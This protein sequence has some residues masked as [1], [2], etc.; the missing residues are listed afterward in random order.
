MIA[1]LILVLLGL[2]IGDDFS[3][4]QNATLRGSSFAP[5]GDS[6]VCEDC[7]EV[8]FLDVGQGDAIYIR[9][10]DEFDILIDGGPNK[11]VLSQLGQVMPFWDHDIDIM[12]LTHPHSDHVT[13]LVEVLRRYNVKE[14]YYTGVPHTT[15][16]YIAWLEEISDQQIPMQIVEQPIDFKLG[17]DIVFQFLYPQKSLK[18]QEITE[19]NNSS[20]VNRLVYGETE[21]LLMG[22]A[23]KEVEEELIANYCHPELDS[24]DS[25]DCSQL[26]SDILK[27]GHHGSS[28]SSSEEFLEVVDPDLAVIQVG[29][30]NSFGHPHNIILDRLRRQEIEV[31]RNDLD[32]RISIYTDGQKVLTNQ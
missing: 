18:D 21:F 15:P 5:Q 6:G 11:N 28:S 2:V 10:P 26:S 4:I 7:L 13:G 12:I 1:G 25:E 24:G 8:H 19:L 3:G 30:G 17:N 31:L 29:Q 16:D 9:T 27:L 32:G 20:I 23:E 14:V 22:D